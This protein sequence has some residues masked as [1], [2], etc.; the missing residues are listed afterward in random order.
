[1][2]LDQVAVASEGFTSRLKDVIDNPLSLV[3]SFDLT[4]DMHLFGSVSQIADDLVKCDFQ[5]PFVDLYHECMNG[6]GACSVSTISANLSKN[7]FVLMGKMTG[8]AE[9]MNDF[10]S[11]D[12]DEYKEQMRELGTDAG[13][14][15][16]VLYNYQTPEQAAAAAEHHSSARRHHS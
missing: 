5:E 13:T 4:K 11:E 1:M 15:L 6:D 8:M 10:P 2:E 3:T 14:F 7:M 16:R 9:T 12:P